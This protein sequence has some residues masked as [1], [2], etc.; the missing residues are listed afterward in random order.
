M[1]QNAEKFT[2]RSSA[3]DKL[4][5]GGIQRGHVLEVS[6]PPGTPKE[7]VATS[8]ATSFVEAGEGVIFVGDAPVSYY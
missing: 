8:I 5:S 7:L 4:L 1:A 2:T 3:I 6:G